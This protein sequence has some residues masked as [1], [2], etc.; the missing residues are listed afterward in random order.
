LEIADS[1]IAL[2]WSGAEGLG[3]AMGAAKKAHLPEKALRYLDLNYRV[4]GQ[5]G[6]Y[7]Q[8]GSEVGIYNMNRQALQKQIQEQQ[9]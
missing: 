7:K 6:P 8:M 9:R 2:G 3:W 1:L 4:N 5:V